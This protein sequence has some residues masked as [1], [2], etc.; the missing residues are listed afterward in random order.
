MLRVAVSLRAF[1]CRM[2]PSLDSRA[3]SF[4]QS[5]FYLRWLIASIATMREIR[6]V[7][8]KELWRGSLARDLRRSVDRSAEDLETMLQGGISN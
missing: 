2:L 4:F 3:D 5:V 6:L 1:H 8:M 7:E